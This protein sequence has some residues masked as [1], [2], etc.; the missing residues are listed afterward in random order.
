[1]VENVG[2]KKMRVE[3]LLNI[4]YKEIT[5]ESYRGYQSPKFKVLDYEL[6]NRCLPM[7]IEE[8]IKEALDHNPNANLSIEV[9]ANDIIRQDIYVVDITWKE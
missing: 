5:S 6:A 7:V 2:P 3:R 4:P 1:M 9:K 8:A